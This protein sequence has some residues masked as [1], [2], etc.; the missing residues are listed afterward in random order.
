MKLDHLT[1]EHFR[2]MFSNQFELVNYA[3]RL[4]EHMIKSGREP[5]RLH[6]PK[7]LAIQI[8]EIIESGK[9]RY[10]DLPDESALIHEIEA[11]IITRHADLGSIEDD[12]EEDD[13]EETAEETAEARK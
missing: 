6:D 5:F 11:V 8:L 12:D 3:I 10:K 7:N 13:E 9:D 1:N 2:N 4:A